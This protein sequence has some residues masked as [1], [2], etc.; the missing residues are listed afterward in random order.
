MHVYR[1]DGV[2]ISPHTAWRIAHDNCAIA[3]WEKQNKRPTRANPSPRQHVVAE[4]KLKGESA[5]AQS[6]RGLRML[7]LRRREPR[8]SAQGRVFLGRALPRG[9]RKSRS[10]PSGS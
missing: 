6:D 2:V 4:V 10:E 3:A 9:A 1:T 5:E 8:V 7:E